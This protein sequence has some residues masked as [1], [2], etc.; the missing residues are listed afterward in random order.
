[1]R[2]FVSIIFKYF[3]LNQWKLIFNHAK[4]YDIKNPMPVSAIQLL[5]KYFDSTIVRDLIPKLDKNDKSYL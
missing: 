4:S 2:L 5:F 1:M 3:F